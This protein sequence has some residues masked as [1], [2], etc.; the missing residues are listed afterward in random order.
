MR[1]GGGR[2][3]AVGAVQQDG[4]AVGRQHL[5]G[6]GTGRLGQ[7]V[8]VGAEVQRP[9]DALDGPVLADRLGGGGDVVLV[10]G[11]VREEPRWPEV[12]NATRWPGSSGSGCRV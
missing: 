5:D 1:D 12:P 3:V 4:H 2:G 10:E 11:R 7:R 8:G 6:G 9:G